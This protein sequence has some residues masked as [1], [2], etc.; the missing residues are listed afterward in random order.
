MTIED[1][2]FPGESSVLDAWLRFSENLETLSRL[3]GCVIPPLETEPPDLAGFTSAV[4]A[5]S[6]GLRE[7][8]ANCARL[9]D[10]VAIAKQNLDATSL[11]RMN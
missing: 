7:L 11:A 4:R 9:R 10:T 1:N 8:Q 5:F 6:A 3:A 2:P